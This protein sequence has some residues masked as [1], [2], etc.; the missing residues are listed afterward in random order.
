LETKSTSP[1][2]LTFRAHDLLYH[3]YQQ[4][5]A[6]YQKA[7]LAIFYIKT[8]ILTNYLQEKIQMSKFVR[9]SDQ[10]RTLKLV[11]GDPP[12]LIPGSTRR[13]GTKAI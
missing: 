1:R 6:L 7:H 2:Y 10:M 9:V 8:R 11:E 3:W 5:F 13:K 4:S 12:T